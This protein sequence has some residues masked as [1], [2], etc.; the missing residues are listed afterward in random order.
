MSTKD[1][2]IAQHAAHSLTWQADRSM[3]FVLPLLALRLAFHV[4]S[5]AINTAPKNQQLVQ[6]HPGCGGQWGIRLSWAERPA[7]DGISQPPQKSAL[8]TVT[9]LESHPDK[10]AHL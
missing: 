3:G 7:P 1:L 6:R 9:L 8:E 2:E 5:I 10:G 4:I